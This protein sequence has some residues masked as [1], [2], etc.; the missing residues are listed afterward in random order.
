[1]GGQVSGK[2]MATEILCDL[3]TYLGVKQYINS[4]GRLPDDSAP[5]VMSVWWSNTDIKATEYYRMI[6]LTLCMLNFS[7]E[8]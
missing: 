6:D 7:E 5:L 1:M 2:K 4:K 8:T 3:M